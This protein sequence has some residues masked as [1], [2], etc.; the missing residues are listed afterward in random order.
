MAAIMYLSFPRQQTTTATLYIPH[1]SVYTSQD[2]VLKSLKMAS[3]V[4]ERATEL[5]G[6]S[7]SDTDEVFDWSRV[8]DNIPTRDV[9]GS[10]M[11]F[12]M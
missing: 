7:H 1:N 3:S 4:N 5:L 12:E 6:F 11:K 8:S 10:W 2:H 9:D